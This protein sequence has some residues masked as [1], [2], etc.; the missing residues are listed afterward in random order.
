[1]NSRRFRFILAGI[2]LLQLPSAARTVSSS[3]QSLQQA[4]RTAV[5]ERTY[6]RI[7]DLLGSSN[8]P[9]Q[10]PNPFSFL[11]TSPL[12]VRTQVIDDILQSFIPLRPRSLP[13]IVYD[14]LLAYTLQ[15]PDPF[16]LALAVL[17]RTLRSGCLPVPQTQLFLSSAWLAR[18]RLSQTVADILHEMRSIGYDPDT[19]TC[20]YLISSLCAVDQLPEAMKVLKGMARAG[21]VPDLESYVPVIG[22][23]CVV[24]KTVDALE[25]LKEMMVTSGLT[26]RQ[27]TI[28]KVAAALRANR[29]IRT[30]FELIEFLE[31]EN[32][33]VGFEGYELVLEGC[34]DCKEYILGAKVAMR[35]TEKGFIPYIKFRLKYPILSCV[36]GGDKQSSEVFIGSV[37]GN[38]VPESSS[39][40]RFAVGSAFTT[41]ADSENSV[42]KTRVVNCQHQPVL[43]GAGNDIG[44]GSEYRR[45]KNRIKPLPAKFAGSL[46]QHGQ[47]GK[48]HVESSKK[49]QENTFSVNVPTLELC[50]RVVFR[51]FTYNEYLFRLFDQ[52]LQWAVLKFGGKQP[53]AKGWEAAMEPN[54]QHVVERKVQQVS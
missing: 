50:C 48:G 29:E 3:S 31:K 14:C 39:D 27:G 51:P 49:K 18:R 54:N 16:P 30:A 40:S 23:M 10:N 11:S 9:W 38:G 37:D 12:Q 5:E 2:P 8:V 46:V 28:K 33:A 44:D 53:F 32:Y 41:G 36:I 47:Q 22:A 43:Q 21:C 20:N 17:Q 4:I 13:K 26:P 15:S 19:G 24:R 42:V 7:P 35:M 45:E 6:Q 1:M 52:C 34:L 25:L